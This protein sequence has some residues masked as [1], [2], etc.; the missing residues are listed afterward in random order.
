MHYYF[1]YV[2]HVF[3]AQKYIYLICILFV[4][5]IIR[6]WMKISFT[7]M[8]KFYSLCI[9]F[10]GFECSQIYIIKWYD[11]NA[12]SLWIQM[13]FFLWFKINS[14]CSW[15]NPICVKICINCILVKDILLNTINP[16]RDLLWLNLSQ[17]S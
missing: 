2:P 10:K 15:F 3:H 17:E 13:N 11:V 9:Q 1:L 4:G 7:Q 6:I 12:S 5:S 16:E 8:M 14:L